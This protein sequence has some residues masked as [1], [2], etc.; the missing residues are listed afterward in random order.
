MKITKTKLKI[1]KINPQPNDWGFINFFQ[2]SSSNSELS[3]C[4]IEYGRIYC[5]YVDINITNNIIRYNITVI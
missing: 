3:N 1:T 4:I 5:E 2:G